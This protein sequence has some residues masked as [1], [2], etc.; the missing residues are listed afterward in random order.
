M[1][2]EMNKKRTWLRTLIAPILCGAAGGFLLGIILL[3]IERA[4]GNDGLFRDPK[5]IIALSLMVIA[6]IL[7]QI[8]IHELGHM[9]C[10]LATGYRF[11]SFRVGSFIWVRE[12]DRIRLKKYSLTGAVGQCLMFPPAYNGGEYP[13]ALYHLGGVIA[14]AVTAVLSAAAA[15]LTAAAAPVSVFF[16]LLGLVGL[17]FALSNGIP[18]SGPL[19]NNDGSN[20]REMRQS[21]EA[22]RSMWIQLSVVERQQRGER[23]KDMPEEW[24]AMPPAQ[25][26]RSSLA[27]TLAVFRENRLMD[28]HRFR[29]AADLIDDLLGNVRNIA[30]PGI[31]RHL[32]ICDRLTIELLGDGDPA[33]IETLC[34]KEQ[35]RV[36]KQMAGMITVLRTEYAL[37]LLYDRDEAKAGRLLAAFDRAAAQYPY[38]GDAES[39]RSLTDLVRDKAAA[40]MP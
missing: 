19:M 40:A 6:A 4:A 25:A 36:M 7:L 32:L 14:N 28:E 15:L 22:R 34:D 38:S 26:M 35:R 33:V 2:S 5:W 20:L 17:A 3:R 29:E 37:A 23:L 31:Y 10:G 1:N 39:E 30:L 11:A 21:A 24:F 18:G 9:L 13:Y 12:N 8:I 27:A 16:I